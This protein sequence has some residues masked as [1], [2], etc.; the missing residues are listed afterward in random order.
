VDGP[1]SSILVDGNKVYVAGSFANAGSVPASNIAVWDTSTE[2]WSALGSGTNGTNNDVLDLLKQ[3]SKIYA[4]GTFTQAGGNSANYVAVWDGTSWS[5][6]GSGT[7]NDVNSI[8]YMQG[9]IYAAGDFSTAG[10]NA[11]NNIAKWNGS[12]W[13]ALGAGTDAEI[14]DLTI[15]GDSVLYAAGSFSNADGNPAKKVAMWDGT[16]WEALGAG[17]DNTVYGLTFKDNTLYAGGKFENSGVT[18]IAGIAK[19]DGNTWK[20][21]GSGLTGFSGSEVHTINVSQDNHLIVGGLFNEVGNKAAFGLSMYDLT[22]TPVSNERETE[23][24]S[25]FTLQQNY[26]NP[27]NPTTNITYKVPSQ[28]PVTLKVYNMLGQQVSTLVN[29]VKAAGSHTVSFDASN[30]SS[31]MYIYRLTAANTSITRKMMLLK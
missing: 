16:N 4:V 6:L 1:V 13:S 12:A 17:L 21:V 30:L 14:M 18:E 8:A 31:G 7:D 19:W 22:E 29:G 25:D 20:S 24:A 23:I 15:V 26:P 11:A 9:S 5:N 2:S 3:G 27:F 10:G 28:S